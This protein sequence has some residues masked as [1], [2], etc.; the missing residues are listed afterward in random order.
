[1]G[2]TLLSIYRSMHTQERQAVPVFRLSVQIFN[3]AKNLNLV[4]DQNLAFIPPFSN[5]HHSGKKKKKKTP[6]DQ[7]L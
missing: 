3:W 1:M 6:W 2:D 4:P 5:P 7:R